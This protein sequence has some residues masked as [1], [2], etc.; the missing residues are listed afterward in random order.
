M[1]REE[2]SKILSEFLDRNK[3]YAIEPYL[4][5]DSTEAIIG[6]FVIPCKRNYSSVANGKDGFRITWGVPQNGLL[7]PYNE[8]IACY[9]ERDEYGLQI[10]HVTMKCGAS[11][12]FECCGMVA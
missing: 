6:R 3:Y 10:V 2:V 12:E 5:N 11:I 8:V 9:E 7:I 4:K 1:N